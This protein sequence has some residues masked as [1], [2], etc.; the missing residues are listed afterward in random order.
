MKLTDYAK[1]VATLWLAVFM[2]LL[3]MLLRYLMIKDGVPQTA[4]RYPVLGGC[5]ASV[6][7]F[8]FEQFIWQM[9]QRH[10]AEYKRRWESE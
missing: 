5:T 4:W 6:I 3:F 9:N 8:C 7:L 1:H 2:L 10:D